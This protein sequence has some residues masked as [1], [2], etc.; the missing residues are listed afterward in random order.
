MANTYSQI[1]YHIVF[2]TKNRVDWIKPEIEDRV[3]AYVGGVARKHTLTAIQIGG[4]DNHIHGL[5]GAPPTHSPSQVAKYLKGDSSKWIHEEFPEMRDFAW[6][7]GYGVFTVSRSEIERVRAYIQNQREHHG[8]QT[9]EEEYKGLLRLHG[10]EYDER[11]L[12][13]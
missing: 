7:D 13:G 3:W 9:F 11:F 12:F 10:I 6:Q 8:K 1:Y 5:L 4:I 2:S